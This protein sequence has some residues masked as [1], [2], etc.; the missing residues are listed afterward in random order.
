MDFEEKRKIVSSLTLEEKAQLLQGQSPTKTGGIP[1]KGFPSLVLMDGPNGLRKSKENGDSLGGIAESEKTTCFPCP[2]LL[3][4]TFDRELIRKVGSAIGRECLF[5]GVNV[6]LGPAI[7]IQRN[8]L[9]GRNFE[10]YSEDPYLSGEQASSFVQGVQEEH[11]GTT[12]KH[13]CCNNNENLRFVGESD[14]DERALHEIYLKPFEIVVKKAKPTAV[15]NSYNLV[16]G[17]HASENGLLNN[18]ILRKEWSFSG[19]VMTDWGGI[20]DREKALENGTDLEMPGESRYNTQRLVKAVQ[21]GRIEEKRLDESLFR[22][23]DLYE[24]TTPHDKKE[25]APFEENF[26]LAEK[27]AEEG[28]VL[29]KNDGILP[30]SRSFSFLVVGEG[31][32]KPRYQGGGSSLLNPYRL[33]THK[34]AFDK[35]GID[36]EY[37]PGFVSDEDKIDSKKEEEALRKAKDHDIVLFFGG[38]NDFIESEGYDRESMGLPSN[39]LSLLGKLLAEKKKVVFLLSSGAPLTLPFHREVNAILDLFLGGEAIGEATSKILFGETSPSGRL[40]AT[41]PL[42]YEDVPFEEEF[43]KK[44]NSFYKESI[45][46]GYRYYQKAQKKVLYPFGYGL[47][48]T[49]FRYSDIQIERKGDNLDIRFTLRN[50]GERDGK[51]VCQL[52]VRKEDSVFDRPVREL[53]GYEK[54]FLRKGESKEVTISLPL[55]DLTVYSREEHRFL[56]EEGTYLFEI[57]KDSE[58]SCL[59]AEFFVP[60]EKARKEENPV[61]LHYSSHLENLSSLTDQ[62]YQTLLPDTCRTIDFF[63]RPYTLETPVFAYRTFFGK[64]FRFFTKLVGKMELSKAKRLP[65]GGERDRQIKAAL[66]VSALFPR[67]C[68]RSLAFSSSGR[69]SYRMA[70][71]LLELINNHPL[72]ALKVLVRKDRKK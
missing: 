12:I 28:I 62:E 24:I 16:N 20:V 38:T 52:Y 19:L 50:I 70:S 21:E 45:Y 9:C 68:L 71:F 34:E 51:E 72:R 39:Q 25:D 61:L 36:Y 27:V 3:A 53:K 40:T 43:G 13:F 22:L 47:S 18:D 33:L 15:M 57:S 55:S 10:Y 46:F 26:L 35:R 42:S 2:T 54:V 1:E 49:R 7:N 30:L 37:C 31:F 32:E 60:G 8:P 44:A 14:V 56:L 48:Y 11:V 66:F 65:K 41:F 58:N 6:L 63:K 67:N 29:L 23:L 5:Y 4:A 17:I 64:F 69:L 59:S